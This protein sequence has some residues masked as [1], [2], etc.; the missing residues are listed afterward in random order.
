MCLYLCLQ[1]IF[2]GMEESGS[3]GLDDLIEKEKE[4]PK[5]F[6]QV[7]KQKCRIIRHNFD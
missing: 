6:F 2:E 3:V 4:K 5:N 1:F 7:I